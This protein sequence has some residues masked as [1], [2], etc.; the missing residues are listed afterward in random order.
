MSPNA[1]ETSGKGM[2]KAQLNMGMVL[3]TSGVME[4]NTTIERGVTINWPSC[5]MNH[6]HIYNAVYVYMYTMYIQRCRYG[7]L[8]V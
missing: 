2:S 6:T 5:V 3:F 8:R 7:M 1:Y 4:K